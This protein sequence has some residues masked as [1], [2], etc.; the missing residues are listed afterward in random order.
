MSIVTQ[1]NALRVL[2][3]AFKLCGDAGL[4]FF[5]MDSALL[6]VDATRVP[7]GTPLVSTSLRERDSFIEVNTHGTYRDSGGW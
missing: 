1:R 5:G 2:S 7:I 3:S 4:A 6:A